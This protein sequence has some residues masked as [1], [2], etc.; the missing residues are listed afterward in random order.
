MNF[1]SFVNSITSST[2]APLFLA[3]LSFAESSF[4]PIPPDTIQIPLSILNPKLSFF[5]ATIST[6]SSVFGGM[7]G[8]FIGNKGGKPIVNRVV[9]DEKLYQVKLLYQKYDVWAIFIAGFS[10]IPY[11]IFTLSAGL[12][13]LNFKRF[14]IAS[15][16]GRGARF[17]LV[18]TLIFFFGESIRTFLDKYLE[19]AIVGF[20]VLLIG[21]FLVVNKLL[22]RKIKKQ[23]K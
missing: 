12:F 13:D 20:T 21:G 5:Y 14:V 23:E 7:F 9:S 11:K 4:F 3:M 15:F 6:F 16:I 8:Y 22:K 18:A 19:L 2:L 17:Y 10:P 1:E